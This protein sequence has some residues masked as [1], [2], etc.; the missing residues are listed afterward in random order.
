MEQQA[1]RVEDTAYDRMHQALLRQR[2]AF[3]AECPVPADVRIDRINRAI[4]LLV[5]KQD[6][7]AEAM[8]ADFGGRPKLMSLFTDMVSSVKALKLAR[9]KLKTWMRPD[10]RPIELPLRLMGAKAWVEYQ[11]KGVVGLVSPWNFP[12]NLT[13]GPLAGIFA[14]GNRVMIK[15][16]EITPATSDLM[17]QLFAQAYDEDEVAVFTGGPEVGQ[18]F[19]SLPFDHL[20]F[21]GAT[22]VGRHVM[23]AAAD[24]LVPVTLELGGKSPVIVS[25]TADTAQLAQRIAVGKMLNAGQVCLAPDYLL[26]PKEAEAEIAEA[27]AG[28]V[29]Q[30]YGDVRSNPDYRSE[31]RR[32]G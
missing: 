17:A 18:A 26:V 20:M 27:V 32:V 1:A 6:A 28:Q 24:N 16:S 15:P 14:A 21:T 29:A 9:S 30:L 2:Q 22:A 4:A 7:L 3:L 23:R 8:A 10:R 25:R 31:E 12:V 5:D 11:P 13:F 19:S